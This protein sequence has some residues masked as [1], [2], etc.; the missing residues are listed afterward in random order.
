MAQVASSYWPM[1]WPS[2]DLTTQTVNIPKSVLNLSIRIGP[3]TPTSASPLRNLPEPAISE[4][5]RNATTIWE[6]SLVIVITTDLMTDVQIQCW[7]IDGGVFGPVGRIRLDE[8][9][10]T[11]GDV[12][13]RI[14][15]IHP[16]DPLSAKTTME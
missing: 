8:T 11:F 2:P 13:E 16:D 5:E 12:S 7:R 14:Y 3:D 9:G 15:M 10:T 4:F 6:G 1:L